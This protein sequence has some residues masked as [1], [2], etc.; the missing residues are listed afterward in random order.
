M[1][2]REEIIKQ[3]RLELARREFF[4]IA[5]QEHQTSIKKVESF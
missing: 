4:F 3:A 5:I 2:S 1:V